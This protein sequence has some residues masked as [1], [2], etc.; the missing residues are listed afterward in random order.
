MSRL[1]RH[2][3]DVS[4]QLRLPREPDAGKDRSSIGPTALMR[5]EAI[6]CEPLQL[7]RVQLENSRSLAVYRRNGGY[8]AIKKALDGMPPDDVINEVRKSALGG[9][10]GAGFPTGM[11]WIFVPK[12]SP[13]PK[14]VVCNADESEPGTFKDRPIMEMDPHALVEGC[15]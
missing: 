10:G 8:E 11:K 15:L 2:C 12:G 14:Y 7:R 5:I 4:A 3:A 9:R 1:V 13:K 6:G